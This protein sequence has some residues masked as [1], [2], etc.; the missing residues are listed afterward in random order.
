MTQELQATLRKDVLDKS[1]FLCADFAEPLVGMVKTRIE[2]EGW[3][4]ADTKALDAMVSCDDM[5]IST[6]GSCC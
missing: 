6:L 4:N 1:S 3:V 5:K 2:T